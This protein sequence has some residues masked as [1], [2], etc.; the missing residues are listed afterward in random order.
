VQVEGF[1]ASPFLYL[2]WAKICSQ[3]AVIN[4]ELL[5]S[6]EGCHWTAEGLLL[7]AVSLVADV[8]RAPQGGPRAQQRKVLGS[9][10]A[11]LGSSSWARAGGN[12]LEKLQ[13]GILLH[14]H[15]HSMHMEQKIAICFKGVLL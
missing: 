14:R 4:P 15:T 2:L 8:L 11:H 6:T 10:A 7:V 13:V 3:A 9:P 5:Q 12:S 1:Q